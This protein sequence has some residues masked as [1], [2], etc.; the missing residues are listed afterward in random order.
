MSVTVTVRPKL[1]RWARQRVS[2]SP[3]ELAISMK[4]PLEK[5]VHW[6]R[7]VGSGLCFW[8]SVC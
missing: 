5:V 4:L 8:C 2:L 7:N 1:L 6:G 3:D